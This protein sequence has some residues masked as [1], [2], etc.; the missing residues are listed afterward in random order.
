MSIHPKLLLS[1]GLALLVYNAALANTPVMAEELLSILR[2]RAPATTDEYSTTLASL[3]KAKVFINRRSVPTAQTESFPFVV[4]PSRELI[5]HYR[6]GATPAEFIRGTV[7]RKRNS[8]LNYVV[9]EITDNN[10]LAVLER[11][12]RTPGVEDFEPRCVS[13]PDESVDVSCTD[14][15]L[16]PY[17]GPVYQPKR[18]PSY[19]EKLDHG[20][21]ENRRLIGLFDVKR[22][23]P[24]HGPPL[25]TVLDSGFN[26]QH[27]TISSSLALARFGTQETA[28]WNYCTQTSQ[29]DN[30]HAPQQLAHGTNMAGLIA[31][32]CRTTEE[33]TD[34][35]PAGI[36]NSGRVFLSQVFRP[37]SG[38]LISY[39]VFADAIVDAK[40]MGAKVI[41]A[42]ISFGKD[43]EFGLQ[44]I[45]RALELVQDSAVFIAGPGNPM[46]SSASPDYPAAF[47]LPHVVAVQEAGVFLNGDYLITNMSS[48]PDRLDLGA[49]VQPKL[50]TGPGVRQNPT[51]LGNSSG[52][53]LVA[54][55]AALLLSQAPS[56]CRQLSPRGVAT[57]L[58]SKG[59]L[60]Q[61]LPNRE[62]N[63]CGRHLGLRFL[64]E[65]GLAEMCA[66]AEHLA[67]D[68]LCLR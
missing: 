68:T 11:I 21:F 25:V 55:A 63:R 61:L 39:D 24:I 38:P 32:R 58:R 29:V 35:M 65:P 52:I 62:T 6:A 40:L 37:N 3:C 46:P 53:A 23:V 16:N 44:V 9:L 15:P 48:W 10:V 42:S 41:S 28:A 36:S 56:D 67:P 27:R 54:G 20:Q 49:P 64:N 8:V 57:L 34:A 33:E 1:I 7:E 19:C 43:N 5:V 14:N 4:I 45:R 2:Q 17:V 50:Y 26:P 60:Y 30:H 18:A 22:N 12:K 59:T 31:G 47:D 13:K 66:N 51:A